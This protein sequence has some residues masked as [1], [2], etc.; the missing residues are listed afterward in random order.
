MHWKEPTGGGGGGLGAGGGGGGRGGDGGG[1]GG[2][3]GGGGDAML[4]GRGMSHEQLLTKS[5]FMSTSS[6]P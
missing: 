6:T 4:E 3:E 1:D 2:G 5:P